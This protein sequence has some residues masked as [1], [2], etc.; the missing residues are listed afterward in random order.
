MSNKAGY[1]QT[2]MARAI[3]AAARGGVSSRVFL[4]NLAEKGVCGGIQDVPGS[5]F[6][7][8]EL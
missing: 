4:G 5:Q 7:F 8:P 6:I 1:T 2:E 3:F